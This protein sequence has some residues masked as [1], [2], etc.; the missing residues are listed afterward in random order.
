MDSNVINLKDKLTKF[1]E[2]WS[3]RVIAEMNNYQFKLAK[4]KD[5]FVW[6]DH[7]DTDEVFL[8]IHGSM[9]IEFTDKTVELNEGEMFVVPKGVKHKPFAKEECHVLL[10]EPRGVVN[11]G[12]NTGGLT[13]LND[14]WV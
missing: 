9:F 12:E 13:A 1:S 11:T 14:V 3:P 10:V 8:V 5:E 7:K 2:H 6:H 4:F